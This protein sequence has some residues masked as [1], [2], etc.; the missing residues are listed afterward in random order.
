MGVLRFIRHAGSVFLGK[1]TPVAAGDYASGTNHVLPTSGYARI[2]SGL[3]V[4][5][6][7]KK[8]TVQLIT[9]DGLQG[10]MQ[11]ITTLAEAEG[12]KAHA[13][14]VRRRIEPKE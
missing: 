9:D 1:Y 8:I 3:N 10:L 6:F 5:H 12:L 13:E 4:D 11:T 2:F 7:M 14:S